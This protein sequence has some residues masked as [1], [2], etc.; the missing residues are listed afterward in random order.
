MHFV[1]DILPQY[2]LPGAKYLSQLKRNGFK[3]TFLGL[4][5]FE[6]FHTLLK[7]SIG[8][9]LLKAGQKKLFIKFATGDK[10]RVLQ[11][12]KYWP[13]IRICL[14]QK[15]IIKDPSMFFDY[16][17]LL[18]YFKKD[19]HS[20]HYV[21]PINLKESHDKLME[22]KRRK[23]EAQELAEKRLRIIEEEAAY[24]RAKSKYFDLLISD[25]LITISVL[26]S[27]QEFIEEGDELHHCVFTNDYH[28]KD[29]SLILS[30]RINGQRLETIEVS[31]K[32]GKVEQ[33]RG[34]HNK[35]TEFHSR[36]IQ[37]VNKNNKSIK[38]VKRLTA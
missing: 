4:T 8:E 10:W 1:Y 30:A 36:I 29:G 19:L 33:S 23:I 14:R 3:G 17:D 6:I 5:P 24:Q 7:E 35:D 34:L 22:R 16:L 9:T 31:L 18:L 28:K 37:L 32:T 27:V 21:C 11:F 13:S 15:Y 26:K 20:S 38:K 2:V 12:T 25:D